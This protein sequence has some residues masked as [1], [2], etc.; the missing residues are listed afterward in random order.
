MASSTPH[1]SLSFYYS[2]SKDDDVAFQ[3]TKMS[4]G[5]KVMNVRGHNGEKLFV[6][7]MNIDQI[8]RIETVTEERE[9]SDALEESVAAPKST[10]A[11][12]MMHLFILLAVVL[13]AHYFRTTKEEKRA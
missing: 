2:D 3:T 1:L 4:E 7:T 8:S 13:C 12:F 9:P 11:Y 6:V 10:A 5:K